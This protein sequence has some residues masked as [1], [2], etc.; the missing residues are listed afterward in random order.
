VAGQGAKRRARAR[1]RR[2]STTPVLFEVKLASVP[3]TLASF[4]ALIRSF[5]QGCMKRPKFTALVYSLNV[6]TNLLRLAK[7]AEFEQRL[8][9][10]EKALSGRS[11]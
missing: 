9:A 5:A 11:Y 3:D 6:Y 1:R 7:E 2:G 4:E 10:L 8:A